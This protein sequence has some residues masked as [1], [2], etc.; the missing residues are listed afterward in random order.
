M[1][2]PQAVVETW[3]IMLGLTLALAVVLLFALM[4][5]QVPMR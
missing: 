5:C 1:K 2:D 4:G 3:V